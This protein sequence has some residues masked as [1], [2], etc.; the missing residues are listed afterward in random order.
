MWTQ[1]EWE[2]AREDYWATVR[3]IATSAIERVEPDSY[4]DWCH[5]QVMTTVFVAGR[6]VIGGTIN[7]PMKFTNHRPS[8]LA[9]AELGQDPG[10]W[11]ILLDCLQMVG[12][13]MNA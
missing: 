5:D 10:Y 9:V 3:I 12:R 4:A 1:D 13:M 7:D 6:D 2:A 11:A 8:A